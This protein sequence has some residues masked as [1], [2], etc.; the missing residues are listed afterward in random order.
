M[1]NVHGYEIDL[2]LYQ[3]N[4]FA[5]YRGTRIKDKQA[6][7]LKFSRDTQPMLK[8][9]TMLQHEYQL[10]NQLKLP[11]VI[12]VLDLIHSHHQMILVYEDATG[13]L[14]RTFLDGKS[15]P[16]TSFF[17]IAIQLI[18]TI[19]TLHLQHITHKNIN[20]DNIIID[21][22]TLN[23]KLINFSI[24]T[25]LSQES[26]ETIE[27]KNLEGALAYFS[28]EQTGRMNRLLDYRSDFYSLGILFYE[29]LTGT[30]PF[31]ETDP[32]EIIHSHLAKIPR[33]V[34]KIN[35]E[36]PDMLAAIIA[37]LL[38]K[39]PEDR[40]ASTAGLKADLTQ[41][42]LQWQSKSELEHFMLGEHDIHDQLI[43][44]QKLYGRETQIEQLLATFEEVSKGKTEF[45]AITGYS[46]I[47]KTS[48]VKSIYK[49][50]TRQHGYFISGK[51]D[52]FQRA[53]PYSALITA[54]KK[55][56]RRLLG[57][58]EEKMSQLKESLLNALGS[59]GEI[60]CNIIPEISLIIGPQPAAT[61]ILAGESQNRFTFTLQS[62][63]RALAS[64]EHPLVIF[65][66]DLQWADSASLQLIQNL[67][68]DSE[69][70][71]FFLIGAYRDNE[72]TADHPLML[73]M[74]QIEKDGYQINHI[75]L[76]PLSKIDIQHLLADNL[77]LSKKSVEP[78]A[79]ILL[80]KTDGNPFF[81]NEFIR[82]IY[83][84]KL[85]IFSYEKREW[86]WDLEQIKKQGITNNV[87]DLLI[88]RIQKL[89]KATQRTLEF[90]AC[91]G[92]NFD[93]NTVSI[94]TEQP[95]SEVKQQLWES[96]FTSF[97]LPLDENYQNALLLDI[98]NMDDL[99][100]QE[101]IRYQFIHDRIQQAAY[102]LIPDE[103]KKKTHL[104]IGR[105]LLKGQL[106]TERDE[107]LFDIVNHFQLSMELITDTAEKNQL[108]LYYYWASKKANT[109]A[110]YQ[111][112]K[113]YAK[114]GIEL[115][116]PIDWKQVDELVLNLH[117]ELAINQYLTGEV[118][119]AEAN[120]QMILEY[121]KDSLNKMEFYKLN[122]E[123][124]TAVNK[125]EEAVKN[126]LVALKEA[127]IF[128]SPEPGTLA[129][130]V[131]VVGKPLVF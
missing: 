98:V 41:C 129:I 88:S 16:F 26:N 34:N 73:S 62:F 125:H 56:I 46:G 33:L 96:I 7:I 103:L 105:L 93:L 2:K 14:L 122:C 99:P 114:I 115:L 69:S 128:L 45:L 32:L 13:I 79:K 106:L 4:Q 8:V 130:L 57:E 38:E 10:L 3:N 63:I 61:E 123:L 113:T 86:I 131:A 12:R 111:A 110:A 22:K 108:A 72:V 90:A 82:S 92:Y 20:P 31:T 78:L 85:L 94:I 19:G 21:P 121:V 54:F 23:I 52:Q 102:Q 42:F 124:L 95:I 117:K 40:Y 27:F 127:N 74:N 101:T 76:A 66:D 119:I 109:S 58:S 118:N 36:I 75:L 51:F 18:D 11:N 47:G 39:T 120:F 91:I 43:I 5:I 84:E 49:P 112:A 100:A 65:L 71:Y 35:T 116:S 30:L 50:V 70:H 81:I 77:N 83:H 37:K 67:L 6:V 17:R 29:I 1:D 53:V 15:L 28:P 60:I 9:L 107:R 24:A 80:K 89:S 104:Q 44:S 48:L 87:V 55:L 59:N 25:Q 97:I 64:R 68:K 126:G